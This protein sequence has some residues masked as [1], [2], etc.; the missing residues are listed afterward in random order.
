MDEIVLAPWGLSNDRWHSRPHLG[1]PTSSQSTSGT[2]ARFLSK[3]ARPPSPS[4]Q[5][6]DALL[7]RSVPLT[8]FDSRP[9]STTDGTVASA[10]MLHV[11]VCG[12]RRLLRARDRRQRSAERAH[13][14]VGLFKADAET[15]KICFHAVRGSLGLSVL[16][17]SR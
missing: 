13:Q 9:W 4:C 2:A 6:H 8:S 10:G 7:P 17:N 5:H 16:C 12:Y 14:L 15:D 3:H 1:E 11:C